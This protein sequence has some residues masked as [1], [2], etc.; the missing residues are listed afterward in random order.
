MT[1]ALKHA[2]ATMVVVRLAADDDHLTVQIA[3]D[4]TGFEPATAT[5][6]GLTALRDRLE[7]LG[8]RL[9]ITSHPGHG[10]RLTGTLP[11]T[12]KEPTDA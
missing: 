1:N 8:G 2:D 3:D 7:S 5:G 11:A 12:L 9:S 6:T 10:T 4:G